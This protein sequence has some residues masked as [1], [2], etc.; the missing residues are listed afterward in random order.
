MAD[1]E[2]ARRFGDAGRKRVEEKFAWSAIADQ[3]I[4]LY[5]RMIDEHAAKRRK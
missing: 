3:T 2:K 1:P 5:Q 4:A